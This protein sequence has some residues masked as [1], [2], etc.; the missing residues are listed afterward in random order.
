MRHFIFL[1]FYVSTSLHSAE[2]WRGT[3]T[4]VTDGDTFW[5]QPSYPIGNNT[6]SRKIRIE[7]IDAPEICQLY[8]KQSKHALEELLLHKNVTI[9]TKRLDD[10]DRDVAKITFETRDVGNW[11]VS[12]GHAWSYHYRHSVGPYAVQERDAQ[13][14][15][16]G[17]FAAS[18]PTE[19]RVFRREHG[20]CHTPRN[21]HRV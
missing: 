2:L 21:E 1:L 15:K 5:V 20:S 6:H 13:S 11:M 3:V 7:G 16:R 17:L 9:N 4:Y 19:P 14:A 10:Y 8:G 18:S 12:Q